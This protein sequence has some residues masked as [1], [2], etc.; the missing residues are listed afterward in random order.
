MVAGIVMIAVGGTGLLVGAA[1]AAVSHGPCFDGCSSGSNAA[2]IVLSVLGGLLVAGGIPTLIYGAKRVPA[3]HEAALP[4]WLGTPWVSA[5][6]PRRRPVGAGW[7][8]QF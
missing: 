8:W 2:G 7:A 5:G 6:D 1:M 3:K 4:A